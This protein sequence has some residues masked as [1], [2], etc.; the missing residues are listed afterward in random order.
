MTRL[1]VLALAAVLVLD[2][3]VTPAGAGGVPDKLP[4]DWVTLGPGPGAEIIEFIQK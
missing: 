1:S 2:G 4:P 3:L